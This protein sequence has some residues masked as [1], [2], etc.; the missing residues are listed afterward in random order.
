MKH[1]T[2][3]VGALGLM[4]ASSSCIATHK[5]VAKT[6]SPVESRVSAT[7]SKNADQDKQLSD[8]SKALADQKKE[9]DEVGTDLSRTKERVTDV[10]SKATAAGQSAQQANQAAAAASQAA[11][12]AQRTA[13]QAGQNVD[14]VEKTLTTTMNAMNKW[15]LSTSTTVLFTVGQ[16][17]LSK[18][19][20]AQLDDFASKVAGY[21]RYQV[22]VQ[23]FTDKTGPAN[24]NESLSA[25]RAEAVSRYLANEHKIPLR[26]ISTLGSGYALPVA[27]DKTRDGRKQNRRVEI[28]LFIPEA[29]SGSTTQAGGV[30]IGQ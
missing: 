5:Y 25:A 13:D 10:D 27:D 24:F 9:I 28:R 7:E 19:A 15:D 21:Q 2:L 18:D 23:G 26:S 20:R 30:G 8:H 17:T 4:M 12:N 16:S 6:V 14:R 1:F 3:T 29:G 22:E 11:G